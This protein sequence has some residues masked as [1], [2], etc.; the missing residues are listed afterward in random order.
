MFGK[1]QY[2]DLKK[3]HTETVVPVT[4]NDYLRKDKFNNVDELKRHRSQNMVIPS[5][6]QSKNYLSQRNSEQSRSDVERA[7]KLAK[8][9][10]LAREMNNKWWGK[11]KQIRND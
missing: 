5:I 11:V 7:Y 6:E 1:L 4:H 10:E 8:Q 3:A 2:D 9:D